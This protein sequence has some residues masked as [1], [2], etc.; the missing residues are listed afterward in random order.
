M[1][2]LHMNLMCPA[3]CEH[4]LT[5]VGLTVCSNAELLGQA[6]SLSQRVHTMSS[7]WPEASEVCLWLSRPSFVET[8][9]VSTLYTTQRVYRPPVFLENKHK[10]KH[11]MLLG[12]RQLVKHR[13]MLGI[14]V[15]K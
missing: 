2:N 5:C 6:T 10:Q 9:S 1:E 15:D 4:P 13:L 8:V 11:V 12:K 3:K 7:D 14:T